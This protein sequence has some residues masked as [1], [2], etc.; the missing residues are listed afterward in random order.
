MIV[1]VVSDPE[2]AV[3]AMKCDESSDGMICYHTLKTSM[4][5]EEGNSIL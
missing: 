4:L 3:N 5:I 2:K 1:G